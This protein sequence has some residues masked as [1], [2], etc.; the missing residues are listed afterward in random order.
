MTEKR[1]LA[2]NAGMVAAL[3]SITGIG[4]VQ[5]FTEPQPKE[6]EGP[7]EADAERIAAAEAK[8]A[9]KAAKLRAQETQK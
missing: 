1:T 4:L 7:S 5:P 2:V 6:P 9:R 8:R 3:L